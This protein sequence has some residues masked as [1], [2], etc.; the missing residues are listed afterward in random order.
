M[1]TDT[2]ETRRYTVLTYRN[3]QFIGQTSPD[4]SYAEAHEYSDGLYRAL[5]TNLTAAGSDRY[6][7]VIYSEQPAPP[8]HKRC[9]SLVF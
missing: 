1:T 3:G 6:E 5:C 7:L 9:C 2:Q 4:L 8:G